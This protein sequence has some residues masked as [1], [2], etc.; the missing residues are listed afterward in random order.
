MSGTSVLCDGS[1]ILFTI[2]FAW[3]QFQVGKF[4]SPDVLR[5]VLLFLCICLERAAEGTHLLPDDQL[6]GKSDKISG[7]IDA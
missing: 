5:D 6:G 7:Q 4:F 1:D 2:L 3:E